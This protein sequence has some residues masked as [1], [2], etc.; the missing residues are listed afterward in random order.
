[1][2]SKISKREFIRTGMY[3]ACGAALGMSYLKT[4]ASDMTASHI[5][6]NKPTGPGKFSHEAMYYTPGE[7]YVTCNLCPNGCVLE[8]GD[9]SVCRNK[10]N[11]KGK[12]Y[13]VAY[14]NPCTVNIDPIEK[15]PLFHFVPGMKVYSLAT[16]GCNLRCLNCQNWTI[17][18]F[19]AKDLNSYDMMPEKIVEDCLKSKCRAIAYTYSEPTSYYEYMYDTA[20]LARQKGLRNILISNG[21]INTR[22]LSELSKYI[23]GANIN[24]KSFKDSIYKELNGGKLKPILNTLSLLKDAG[25]MLEITNLVVPTWTDDLKMIREMC[26]WLYDNG[27]SEYPLHFSRFTPMYKLTQLPVTPVSVLD[28]AIKIAADAGLKYVYIGNVPAHK[29]EN[30]YCPSCKKTII[31]RKGFT[32]LSNNIADGKCKFCKHPIKGVW[33]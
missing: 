25:V 9:F 27:F 19:S 24:L 17:S 16:G 8:P 18:Q 2:K 30:T 15:K 5:E 12:L 28:S 22:P 26:K 33:S 10:T 32:V 29:A 23:D 20:K 7:G 11:E 13:T 14:G 1:M 21:Y 31:E 4:I 3:G 6:T